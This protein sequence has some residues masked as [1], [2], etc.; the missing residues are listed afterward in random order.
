MI[1]I[2][3][4]A[5]LLFFAL[6]TSFGQMERTFYQSFEIDSAQSISIKLTGDFELNAWAGNTILTETNI[7]I[8]QASAPIL[9][10]F[11]KNGRFEIKMDKTP[12]DVLLR[13]LLPDR[14]PIKTSQGECTEV[15]TLKIFVPDTFEWSIEDKT[16]LVLKPKDN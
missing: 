15:V 12:G 7:Q 4:A 3:L 5:A 2:S 9:D 16:H 11:I 1:R 13:H 8:W 10:Y 14:K 6:Q